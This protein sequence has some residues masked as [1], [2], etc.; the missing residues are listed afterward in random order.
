MRKAFL[1][2]AAG[3]IGA[4]VGPSWAQS[5]LV[6]DLQPSRTFQA[7]SLTDD[8]GATATDISGIACMPQTE[9]ARLCLVINDEDKFAQ[10]VK[11]KEHRVIGGQRII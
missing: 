4:F 6:S 2:V 5:P 10:F 1:L 11:L 8:D 9:A 3:L 7:Q